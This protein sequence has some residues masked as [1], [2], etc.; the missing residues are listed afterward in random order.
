MKLYFVFFGAVRPTIDLIDQKK[1]IIIHKNS[2][3][4][5]KSWKGSA[6]AAPTPSLLTSFVSSPFLHSVSAITPFWGQPYSITV[7]IV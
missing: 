1:Y 3:K 7:H 2:A 4:S 5:Q 6:F